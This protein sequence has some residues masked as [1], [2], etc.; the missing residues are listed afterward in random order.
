MLLRARQQWM[1]QCQLGSPMLATAFHVSSPSPAVNYL[2]KTRSGKS[3]SHGHHQRPL[4]LLV[5]AI[6]RHLLFVTPNISKQRE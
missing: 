3:H 6:C 1:L 5:A 2:R 4:R